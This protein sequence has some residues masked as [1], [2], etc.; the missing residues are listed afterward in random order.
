MPSK[1]LDFLNTKEKQLLR[2][3]AV[4]ME[5][6]RKSVEDRKAQPTI[7]IQQDPDM[8]EILWQHI[9]GATTSLLRCGLILGY[10]EGT[11]ASKKENP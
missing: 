3:A 5:R 11:E 6:L 10:I 4:T 2:R 1:N 9:R 7:D 8:D